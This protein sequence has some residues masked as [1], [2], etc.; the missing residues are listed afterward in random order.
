MVRELRLSNHFANLGLVFDYFLVEVGLLSSGGV[1][2]VVRGVFSDH[3]L[4]SGRGRSL[5]LPILNRL[6]VGLSLRFVGDRTVKERKIIISRVVDNFE[7]VREH[8]G[9]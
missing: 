4:C 1:I 6:A 8:D 7:R 5:Q 9:R 2:A 3:L